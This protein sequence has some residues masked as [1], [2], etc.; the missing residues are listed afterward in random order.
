MVDLVDPNIIE[1]ILGLPR[2]D[3]HHYGLPKDDGIF[4]IMHSRECVSNQPDLRDCEFS[5]ALGRNGVDLDLFNVNQSAR[6]VWT[7]ISNYMLNRSSHE[8]MG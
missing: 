3:H 5:I 7:T 4:Y 6:L 2:H 1:T 8:D